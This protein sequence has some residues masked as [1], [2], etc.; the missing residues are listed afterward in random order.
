MGAWR[1]DNVCYRPPPKAIKR[2]GRVVKQRGEEITSCTGW[3]VPTST[4][5]SFS[6]R[7][8]KGRGRALVSGWVCKSCKGRDRGQAQWQ[9]GIK[10]KHAKSKLGVVWVTDGRA[11]SRRSWLAATQPRG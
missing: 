11:R 8:G 6:F 3:F 2:K 4:L 5:S 1:R 9:W 7:G 10:W